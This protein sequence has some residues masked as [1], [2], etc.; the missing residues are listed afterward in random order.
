VGQ[1]FRPLVD[2]RRKRL[3]LQPLRRPCGR[4]RPDPDERI[5]E[6]VLP[7]ARH[8]AVRGHPHLR[9]QRPPALG[10]RRRRH[11]R[12]SLSHHQH[13]GRDRPQKSP[14]LQ[15]PRN[16]RR[17]RHRA[18]PRSGRPLQF[19]HQRRTHLP[20]PHRPR[21]PALPR[22]RHRHAEP[23][24]R[25]VARDHSAGPR[26]ARRRLRR[27]RSTH[28]RLPQRR[29]ERREMLRLLRHTHPRSRPPRDRLGW[30]I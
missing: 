9:A 11:R 5:P 2:Q 1:I 28:L 10:H 24:P 17:P 18:S 16:T 29:Q 3:L 19:H 23:R 15:R 12:R 30:R 25:V 26:P 27:R 8:P 7:P 21:C 22:H 14:L 13:L 20:L 6:N 4:R